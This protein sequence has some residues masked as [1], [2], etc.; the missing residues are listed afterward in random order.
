MHSTAYYYYKKST[1]CPI[2][3]N[4]VRLIAFQESYIQIILVGNLHFNQLPIITDFLDSVSPTGNRVASFSL[5]A[6]YYL[7]IRICQFCKKIIHLVNRKICTGFRLNI[8]LLLLEIKNT[9]SCPGHATAE[10]PRNGNTPAT[11]LS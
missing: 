9:S 2:S 3:F 1:I 4:W 8:F 6:N 10:R 5:S 11:S 7:V